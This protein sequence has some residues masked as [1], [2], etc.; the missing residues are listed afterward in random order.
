MYDSRKYVFECFKL[1]L[2]KTTQ[3]FGHKIFL[4]VYLLDLMKGHFFQKRS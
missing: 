3:Y 4:C 1:T 2:T